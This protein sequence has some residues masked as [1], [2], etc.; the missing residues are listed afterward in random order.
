MRIANDVNGVNDVNGHSLA[1]ERKSE[2]LVFFGRDEQACQRT[3]SGVE[4]Y[5]Q[6]HRR[7]ETPAKLM[8]NLG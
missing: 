7:I 8:Q 1:E 2:V 3:V 5:L 6:R 4:E